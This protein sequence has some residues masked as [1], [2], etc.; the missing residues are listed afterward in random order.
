MNDSKGQPLS[1]RQRV[2][3][4]PASPRGDWVIGAV[5]ATSEVT[6][7]VLVQREDGDPHEHWWVEPGRLKVLDGG[8]LV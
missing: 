4:T 1:P 3:L 5:V 8:R 7:L 6:G 2:R